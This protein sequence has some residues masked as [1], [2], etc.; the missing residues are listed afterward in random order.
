M[1]KTILIVDP[2]D[3]NRL[4]LSIILQKL[5]YQVFQADNGVD[6]LE[7][8]D[9][10]LPGLVISE[11]EI[12]FLSGAQLVKHIKSSKSALYTPVLIVTGGV[13]AGLILDAIDSG[14]DDYIQKPYSESLFLA[15]ILSLFRI[16][17]MAYDLDETK[18]TISKLHANLRLE[19]QSAE[20]IF[21][22]FVHG[23]SQ[24]IYGLD[25]HISPVSIFNG[26][27]MLSCES[28][29]GEII[30]LLGDFTGHGLPAAIGAIPVAEIF[31]AMVR[32]G[33]PC[34]EIISVINTKLKEILPV[35]IFFACILVEVISKTNILRSFN[36][37][38]QSILY[39]DGANAKISEIPSMVPPLGVLDNSEIEFTLK[40]QVFLVEDEL[41][42]FT[43][44]VVEVMDASENMFGLK[45]VISFFETAPNRSVIKLVEMVQ[46]FSDAG[47]FGDDVSIVRLKLAEISFDAICE[48][49]DVKSPLESLHEK[50]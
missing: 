15:K 6:A 50:L 5:N 13:D 22:K 10:Q 26:D 29:T 2:S 24:E 20:R 19:H 43:D 45:R 7:L 39:F 11:L 35:H 34:L 41:I 17:E 49:D 47:N 31:Y 28:P 1:K 4:Y 3:S 9:V 33:K 21:E 42:I 48:R 16:K 8:F 23:P 14:A 25:K 32:K 44:G 46:D 30:I 38:M 36:A 12:P 40:E 27:V 37:G 18:K